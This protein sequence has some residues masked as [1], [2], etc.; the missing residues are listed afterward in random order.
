MT[1]K[2][3]AIDV[4]DFVLFTDGGVGEITTALGA[5]HANENRPRMVSFAALAA[6]VGTRPAVLVARYR[7]DTTN[8]AIV[9]RR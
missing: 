6:S 7:R 5:L 2:R 9:D 8:N 1:D 3:A 4:G